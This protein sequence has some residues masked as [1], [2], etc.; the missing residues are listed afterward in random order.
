MVLASPTLSY[1]HVRLEPLTLSHVAGLWQAGQDVGDTGLFTSVPQTEPDTRQY[2]MDAFAAQ[3]AGAAQPF[4][5]IAVRSREVV[6]STRLAAFEY[7]NWGRQTRPERPGPDALEI[8]W[9]WLTQKAQRT[10]INT[11]AKWLLLNY[12]FETLLVER[13]LIKTDARNVRSRAAIERLGATFE[14]VLRRHCPAADGGL[15]D[16]AM[17]SIIAPEWSLLKVALRAKLER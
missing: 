13:V 3:V 16:T 5:I 15:R 8:G 11:E 7:W 10:P 2:V 14:G 1:R 9:T 12:A 6:G 17:Y 4:A